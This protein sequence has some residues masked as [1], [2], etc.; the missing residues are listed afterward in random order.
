MRSRLVLPRSHRAALTLEMLA[1]AMVGLL[2]TLDL[3]DSLRDSLVATE[4][5]SAGPLDRRWSYIHAGVNGCT[6]AT[7]QRVPSILITKKS[8]AAV[9]LH[10]QLL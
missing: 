9:G 5:P 3:L 6:P 8:L 7:C 2:E 4:L 1:D 10:L